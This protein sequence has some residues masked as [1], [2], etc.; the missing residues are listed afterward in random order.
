[1]ACAT[2]GRPAEESVATALR[3]GLSLTTHHWATWWSTQ[4]AAALRWGRWSEAA[5]YWPPL[6][7]NPI[8]AHITG[9]RQRIATR[10]GAR[11]KC[12]PVQNQVRNLSSN[13]ALGCGG[14]S[15]GVGE[16]WDP[17]EDR[18]GFAS[19]HHDSRAVP[20]W[21]HRQWNVHHRQPSLSDLQVFGTTANRI[22]GAT[23]GAPHYP[24]FRVQRPLN[25]PFPCLQSN[26]FRRF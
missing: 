23:S 10:Q 12:Q 17:W 14:A 8:L 16:S 21:A 3:R 19:L 22:I 2:P 11:R 26:T 25:S 15:R 20:R 4:H 1:M 13:R 18:D 9:A 5:L 7:P 24:P 6:P